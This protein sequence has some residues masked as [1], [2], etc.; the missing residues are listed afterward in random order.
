MGFLRLTNLL[1]IVRRVRDCEAP[2]VIGGI[3]L[4]PWSFV[5]LLQ[6]LL[7]LHVGLLLMMQVV[8]VV[9]VVVRSRHRSRPGVHVVGKD[10]G[11]KKRT[12]S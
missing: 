12:T 10:S 3:V 1:E 5:L 9:A 11:E 6:L 8:V 2:I 4:C 7:L